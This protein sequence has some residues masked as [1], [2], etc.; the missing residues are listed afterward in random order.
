M[1]IQNKLI[2]SFLAIVCLFLIAGLMITANVMQMTALESQVSKEYAIN[3]EA[4]R[5]DEGAR[6]LQVGVYLYLQG[7]TEMGNQL[8]TEG[9][10]Q[11][12]SSRENLNGLLTDQ[13]MISDLG[14]ISG[15][16]TKV[17]GISD[18]IITISDSSQSNRAALLNQRL[19]TL[20]ARIEALNLRL[21]NLV[22]RTNND[23]LSAIQTSKQNG[24]KTVLLT[25]GVIMAT[26]VLALFI[27]WFIARQLTRPIRR[28][29]E[30]AD[31]VSLGNLEHDITIDSDDEIG[32]LSE[33]FRRMINAF[34]MMDAMSRESEEGEVRP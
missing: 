10:Q 31:K 28:L 9:R 26:F 18:N 4:V 25:L 34:K 32:D 8:I 11:M 24:E 29:T 21:S 7:N 14:E 12:A 19:A 2:L 23:L 33:S 15:L 1:K 27:A 6:Q 17:S 5:Y 16:E 30:I 3:K 13:G 22:D 20:Q